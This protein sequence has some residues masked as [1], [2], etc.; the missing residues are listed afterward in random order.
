MG[1]IERLEKL[2]EADLIRELPLTGYL[3]RLSARPGEQIEAKISASGGGSYSADVV[4][5][6]SAD[7]N[8]D[9]PGLMYEPVDFGLAGTYPARRQE[10]DRG[11]YA[12]MPADP[13]FTRDRLLISLLVEPWLLRDRPATL[14]AAL[15]DNRHGWTLTAT[16][17]GLRLSLPDGSRG[18]C[19]V[20]LGYPMAL[21][22]WHHVWAGWDRQ[23]GDLLIGCRAW[24]DGAAQVA[25]I[26]TD[27]GALP[28]AA[29]PDLRRAK[30]RP[31]FDAPLQRPAG[32]SLPAV[33]FPNG[34]HP[35]LQPG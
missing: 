33:R 18:K 30:I 12:V 7:P 23:S 24:P 21:R 20:S 17:A 5:I 32:R 11:S 27:P 34:R 29:P 28:Q 31:A 16:E 19:T 25:R 9:G 2:T 6:L 22:R 1:K 10:I 4:R 3:D 8:P 14:A 15:D 13:L 35:A 26:R